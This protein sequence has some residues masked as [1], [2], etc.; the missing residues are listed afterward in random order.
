MGLGI[1]V[2][3][4]PV[5]YQVWNSYT[6]LLLGVEQ[7]IVGKPVCE[8]LGGGGVLVGPLRLFLVVSQKA[9]S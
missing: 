5:P 7:S 3:S 9:C 8:G 4:D 2:V 1:K 6:I